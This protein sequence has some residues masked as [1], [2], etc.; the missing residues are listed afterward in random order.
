[1]DVERKHTGAEVHLPSFSYSFRSCSSQSWDQ[2]PREELR[3]AP[4]E[5]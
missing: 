2:A 5:E 4:S 3:E 1:M